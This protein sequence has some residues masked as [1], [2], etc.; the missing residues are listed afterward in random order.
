MHLATTR[1]DDMGITQ[2][3]YIAMPDL[4]AKHT[5]DDLF[6]AR[7]PKSTPASQRRYVIHQHGWGQCDNYRGNRG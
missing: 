2:A 6:S 4:E 1:K 7:A 3:E 5:L